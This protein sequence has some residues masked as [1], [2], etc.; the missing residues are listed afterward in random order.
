MVG[1]ELRSNGLSREAG[2]IKMEDWK[3]KKEEKPEREREKEKGKN[4][5]LIEEEREI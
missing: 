5:F 3:R 2:L 1:A 4:I